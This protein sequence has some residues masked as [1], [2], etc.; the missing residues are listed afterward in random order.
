MYSKVLI[1][2]VLSLSLFLGTALAEGSEIQ[3]KLN[4]SDPWLNGIEK[5][6]L[7]GRVVVVELWGIN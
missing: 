7:E 1:L 5:E 2:L 6:S 3:Q 4:L